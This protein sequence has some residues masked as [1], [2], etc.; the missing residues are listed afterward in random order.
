MK[1]LNNL[2]NN[3]T[4][5]EN[6][7][8]IYKKIRSNIKNKRKIENFENYYIENIVN[9]KNILQNKSYIVG[10]Y[11]IFIIKEPKVRLIMSQNITD[12]VINHLCSYY[13]LKPALEKSLIDSNIATRINKGTKYG[14]ILI[15]KYLNEIKKNNKDIYYLKFDIKKYFYNIDHNILKELLTKKIKDEYSLNI[16]Y[17]IIDSTNKDYI[18][19]TIKKYNIDILYKN[20]KGLPIGN[21]SSQILAIYYL[22][23]LDH[24]IKEKLKIKYYVKYMDDGVIIH[25]DKEYLKYCLK[26]IEKIVYKYKLELNEKTK[27]GKIC[28]GIDFL[29]FRFYVINKKVILRLRNNTKKRFKKRIKNMYKYKNIDNN[30]ISSYKGHMKYG[31]T[32]YLFNNNIKKYV[33]NIY[34]KIGDYVYIDE[35]GNIIRDNTIGNASNTNNVYNVNTNS[36]LNNN[37][38]NNDSNNGA[39][40]KDFFKTKDFIK[41]S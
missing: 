33:H 15:K 10:K 31:N 3:I 34:D 8:F 21:M 26:E 9:I 27:I 5:L 2:Y 17:K 19:K 4:K 30:V 16:I 1:R 28:N 37:N 20:N 35:E 12:K 13:I 11:N 14:I 25:N 39:S 22:N 38:A 6:I 23:E 41:N 36:N 24:Y 29:G 18:N 7:I 32:Y 40:P